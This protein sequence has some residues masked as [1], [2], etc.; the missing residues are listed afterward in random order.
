[1]E[2]RPRNAGFFLPT[3]SVLWTAGLRRPGFFPDWR[4]LAA[5]VAIDLLIL[6]LFF[7]EGKRRWFLMALVL[8]LTLSN[9]GV[10]PVMRGLAPF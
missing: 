7:C 10:N 6:V 4:Q 8:F 3:C 5:A 2:F 9:V 1:M